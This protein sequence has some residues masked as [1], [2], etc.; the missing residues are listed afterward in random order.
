MEVRAVGKFLRVQ[1]RKVRIVADEL[2][3]KSAVYSAAQLRYH[4]SKSARMLRKVLVSAIANAQEN[5]GISPE[6]LRIAAIT[7]DAGPRIKRIQARA[8][9]RAYRIEKK[10]SH[11]TVTVEEYE[12]EAK[13]KPHGTKSKPRPSFASLAKA[14]GKKKKADEPK[15]EEAPVEAVAEETAETP[16]EVAAEETA[17][18]PTEAPA[19]ETSSEEVAPTAE[20]AETEDKSEEA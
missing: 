14:A 11:I 13:I 4:P 5:L 18:A 2:R 19:E 7:V 17:E 20:S 10:T 1:P 9:G 16:V 15:P 3:G 12:G 6:Q 8:M